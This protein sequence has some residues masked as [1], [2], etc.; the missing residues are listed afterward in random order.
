VAETVGRPTA[1]CR[2]LARRARIKLEQAEGASRF[3]VTTTEHR[4][5]M[6]RFIEACA[7]GDFDALVRVLDPDVSGAVDLRP[8]LV[9]HGARNV[10]QNIIR[11]WGREATLVSLPGS[12]PCILAFVDRTLAALIEF[13]LEGDRVREIHVTARP[14]SLLTLRAQLAFERT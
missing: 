2:Q 8:G 5:V 6:E 9:V 13:E 4:A 12:E 1:T 3:D 10:A 7:K 14:E 11:F